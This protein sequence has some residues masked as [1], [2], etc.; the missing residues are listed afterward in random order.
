MDYDVYKLALLRACETPSTRSAISEWIQRPESFE[1]FKRCVEGLCRKY[2][3]RINI[4]ALTFEH[5]T[6]HIV[7]NERVINFVLDK[8]RGGC[9]SFQLGPSDR[10]I[11]QHFLLLICDL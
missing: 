10:Y 4:K 7:H 5:W 9:F 11:E 2:Q 8:A 3:I 1:R 6:Y